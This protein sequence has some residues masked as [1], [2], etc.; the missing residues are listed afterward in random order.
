MYSKV[1]RVKYIGASRPSYV[2]N[3]LTTCINFIDSPAAALFIDSH[4]KIYQYP[5]NN[6]ACTHPQ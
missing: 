5:Y 6:Y 1:W 2:L 3:C 4:T